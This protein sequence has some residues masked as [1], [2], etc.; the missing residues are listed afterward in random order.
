MIAQ[1]PGVAIQAH[2]DMVCIADPGKTIDFFKDPIDPRLTTTND[3][4]YIVVRFFADCFVCCI[5][6][7]CFR[8]R[9][10]LS[11]QM[12]ASELAPILACCV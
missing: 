1:A 12:T 9:K 8:E 11:A 2:M 5:F 4:S 10:P 6:N 3:T 7:A